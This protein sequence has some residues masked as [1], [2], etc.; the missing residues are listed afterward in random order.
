MRTIHITVNITEKSQQCMSDIK[1]NPVELTVEVNET[2][3]NEFEITNYN[4]PS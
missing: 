3:N 1:D 2:M 4:L